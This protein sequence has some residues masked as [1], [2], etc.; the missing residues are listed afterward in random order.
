M[1]AGVDGVLLAAGCS[2]RAGVFKMTAPVGGQPLLLWGVAAL[3]T[4]CDR[5][6]VVAGA[7]A[8]K[9]RSLMAGR[10]EVEV[11]VNEDFASGMLSSVQAGARSVR[12]PRFFLLPGDMPLVGAAV[13][14]KML[15][16]EAEI[17]VP[18]CQGRRGHPVLMSSRLVAAILAEPRDSSL[19]RFIRRQGSQIVETRDPGV[20]SD[21]DDGEDMKRIDALLRVGSDHE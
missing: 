16:R 19:G 5:V 1:G 20:L 12:A 10:P 14:R 18:A 9:V 13:F 2:R 15:E 6:I 8:D 17:V 11:V 21:L 7:G 3:G 4:V